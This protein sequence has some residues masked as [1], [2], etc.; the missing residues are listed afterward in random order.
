[1]KDFLQLNIYPSREEIK[2]SGL[3][4]VHSDICILIFNLSGFEILKEFL[5]AQNRVG[6]AYWM[7]EHTVLL[8]R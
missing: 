4:V 2:I 7:N 1:M 3:Y 6:P 5:S 8:R